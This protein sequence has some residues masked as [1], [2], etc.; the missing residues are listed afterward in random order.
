MKK[1]SNPMESQGNNIK[2]SVCEM[3]NERRQFIKTAGKA[4]TIAPAVSLLLSGG[5]IPGVVNAVTYEAAATSEP[6]AAPAADPLVPEP[7]LM[8]PDK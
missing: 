5:V 2:T 1:F 6:P 7:P 4:T 8:Y 3:D